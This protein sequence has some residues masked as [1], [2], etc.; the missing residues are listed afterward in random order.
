VTTVTRGTAGGRNL[1]HSDLWMWDVES[2]SLAKFAEGASGAR[3]TSDA[4]R[5]AYLEQVSPTHSRLVWMAADGSGKPEVLTDGPTPAAMIGD[6]TFVAD[7]REALARDS[8]VAPSHIY[9]V[10]LDDG[11]PT[12]RTKA[13]GTKCTCVRTGLRAG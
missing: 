1:Q 10:D 7:G 4:K 6:L 13:D 9:S 11:W 3:W 8:A 5:I 2:R 12:C